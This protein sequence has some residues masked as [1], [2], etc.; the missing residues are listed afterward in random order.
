MT[1]RFTIQGRMAGANE[2]N[3]A[4]RRNRYI[5]AKLEQLEVLRARAAIR[6]AALTPMRRPVL[7]G[8]EF[9]EPNRRRDPGNVFW[10]DKPILDALQEE[11]IIGND[12]WSW[13]KGPE[14]IRKRIYHDPKSPRI[15][16]II[17][18]VEA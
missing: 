1:Q 12:N 7:I 16:V 11:G 9:F 18:E 5:G 10:A 2:I 8:I 17:K 3:E 6:Q 15:V 14:P 13:L 4:N